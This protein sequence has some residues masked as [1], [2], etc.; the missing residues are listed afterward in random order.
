MG[1]NV[2]KELIKQQADNLKHLI[3]KL[4]DEKILSLEK[5]RISIEDFQEI[6]GQQQLLERNLS[7]LYLKV[8]QTAFEEVS[9]SDTS[10]RANLAAA[11]ANLANDILHL[12]QKR[13][14]LLSVAQVIDGVTAITAQI[15]KLAVLA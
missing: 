6:N 3:R 5:G 13:H 11:T 9:L 14:F 15:A 4:D 12:D 10:P 2:S 7:A 8:I 1:I